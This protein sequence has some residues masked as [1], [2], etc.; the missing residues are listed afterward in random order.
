MPRTIRFHL[1]EDVDP[2]IAEG[3]RRR[4]IDVTTSQEAGLLGAVDPIQLAHA[5]A[6]G[7]MLFTHDDDHLKM[8]L[9]S[10]TPHGKARK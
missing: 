7:R 6:E 8:E 3:L 2:V 5:R 10:L 4:G 1:D 9:V